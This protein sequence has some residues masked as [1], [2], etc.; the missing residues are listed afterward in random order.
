MRLW[1]TFRFTCRRRAATLAV[2]AVLG[3]A[4]RPASAQ[5]PA[6]TTPPV[7][8][9]FVDVKAREA[10]LPGATAVA[11]R[12]T[13]PTISLADAVTQ[14]VNNQPQIKL[15]IQSVALRTRIL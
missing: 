11:P 2:I 8:Q 13:V 7:D 10:S 14:T 9:G 3:I 5:P 15:G 1:A 12:L 6:T 4:N